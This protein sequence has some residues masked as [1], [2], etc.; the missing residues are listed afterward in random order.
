MTNEITIFNFKQNAV[1]TTVIDGAP[2]FCGA[3]VCKAIGIKNHRNVLSRLRG[4]VHTADTPTTS[5]VQAIVYISE[6][7]LYKVVLQSR[8]PE[9]E[10][11]VD[12]VCGEVLPTIRKTGG[13]GQ[14]RAVT[15][16]DLAA[17]G[18]TVKRCVAKAVRDEIKAI[19]KER[20]PLTDEER[21]ILANLRAYGE[22]KHRKGRLYGLI[23][24]AF[25]QSQSCKDMRE[26]LS[27]ATPRK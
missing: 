11:F 9:S 15:P 18:G 13:Y 5:G 17:I 7:N 12:W 27:H 26:A 19:L 10:P 14:P 1:R 21:L 24:G 22:S 20:E 2:F 16:V 6:K 23:D 8:K 3:D 4:D 25:K